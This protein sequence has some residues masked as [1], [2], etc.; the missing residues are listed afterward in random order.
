MRWPASSSE[1]SIQRTGGGAGCVAFASVG[2]WLYYRNQRA[3]LAAEIVRDA[4]S[5]TGLPPKAPMQ[6]NIARLRIQERWITQDP[7]RARRTRIPP[8]RH[9]NHA[10]DARRTKAEIV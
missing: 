8:P 2:I 7:I 1:T 9:T 4:P 5:I 3:A 10:A 6:A